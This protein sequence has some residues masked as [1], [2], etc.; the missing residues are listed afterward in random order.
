LLII[1]SHQRA[2]LLALFWGTQAR[3]PVA[4]RGIHTWIRAM[5][6][7]AASTIMIS[8]AIM[9]HHVKY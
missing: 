4:S 7:L 2:A 6:V 9:Q 3:E 5:I 8:G 1:L